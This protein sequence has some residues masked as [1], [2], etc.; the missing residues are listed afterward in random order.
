M[1]AGP[2]PGG[3]GESFT[4][5]NSQGSKFQEVRKTRIRI[6]LFAAQAR[7]GSP[8]AT[9][10]PPMT[11]WRW[12]NSGPVANVVALRHRGTRTAVLTLLPAFMQIPL[13]LTADLHREQICA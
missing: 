9:M 10:C 8:C 4:N 3:K 6:V 7:S 1:R 11:L 2:G 13:G 12:I 5:S